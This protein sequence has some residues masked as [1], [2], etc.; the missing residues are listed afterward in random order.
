MAETR[1]VKQL[2]DLWVSVLVAGVAAT[3]CIVGWDHLIDQRRAQ[4]R[5]MAELTAA[6]S[7]R[8]VEAGVRE[9]V[10]ALRNLVGFW[11]TVG[12]RPIEEWRANADILLES[13]PALAYLVWDHPDGHRY[14]MAARDAPPATIVPNDRAKWKAQS[15]VGPERD[16]SGAI[17]FR[18]FLP[19]QTKSGD[20]GALEARVNAARLLADVLQNWAPG[21]AIRVRWGDDELFRRGEPARDPS[22]AWWVTEAPVPLIVGID[23]S[24]TL[25][26]TEELAAATLTPDAHYLL[27]VGLFLALAL[28]LLTHELQSTFRR[29]RELT[30]GQR[31]LVANRDELRRLNEILEARVADRTAELETLTQSFSHDLK[32][33]LGAILN[34]SA[35]LDADYRDRLDEEGVEILGRIRRSAHRATDLLDGLLRLDRARS[36]ALETQEIDMS[37]LARERFARAKSSPEDQ[38]V[39]WVLEPLPNALGDPTLVAEVLDNLFDNALKFSRGRE[40]RRV[41]MRGNAAGRESV[42]EIADNGM[43]LDMQYAG[44]LFGVFERLHTSPEIP[45]IG[46]GLA[47]VKKIIQRHSGRVWAEGEV[48]AGARVTFTLPAAG[49]AS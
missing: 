39:E 31:Q 14:S 32:S 24:V 49:A 40:K 6:Q 15:V 44:K 30:A 48:N 34:F 1:I 16:A 28:G 17:G 29:E 33:P 10:V 46:V 38:E 13:F 36:A 37:A 3:L 4:V 7:R 22:L 2:K 9:Y 8:A 42:Y 21:Y 20:L 19:V 23:W 43:G 18:L 45:G 11:A 47:L 5:T 12:V 41:V 35:I 25:E 27:V 26:P